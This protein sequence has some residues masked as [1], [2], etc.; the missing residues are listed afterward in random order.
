MWKLGRVE[1]L[2][3]GSDGEVRGPVLMSVWEGK[4]NQVLS[5]ASTKTLPTGDAILS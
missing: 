1:R 4:E 2:L 3:T 5:V